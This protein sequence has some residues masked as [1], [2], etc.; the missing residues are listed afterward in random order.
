MKQ[1]TLEEAAKQILLGEDNKQNISRFY[2]DLK[3]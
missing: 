3:V 1:T 2:K